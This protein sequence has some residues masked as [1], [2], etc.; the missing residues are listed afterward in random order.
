MPVHVNTLLPERHPVLIPK[1]VVV[2]DALLL[3]L[4]LSALIKLIWTFSFEFFGIQSFIPLAPFSARL[5][6]PPVLFFS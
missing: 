6:N 3:S 5:K 2:V 1:H 4:V